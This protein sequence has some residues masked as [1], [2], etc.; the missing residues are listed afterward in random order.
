M[1]PVVRQLSPFA[2]NDAARTGKLRA[3]KFRAALLYLLCASL[4]PP[5]RAIVLN[6]RDYTPLAGWAAANQFREVGDGSR[7]RFTLTN[8]AAQRLVFAK[9]SVTAEINSVKVALS[10][11]VAQDKAGVFFIAQ[12]D[13]TKTV[14]PLIFAPPVPAKKITT[15]C[16]DPGHGGKDPGKQVGGHD[17][18]TY[19]LLLA[20]ELR[21]QLVQAG[22]KVVLTRSQ[23][24]FLTLSERA[25]VA[26]RSRADLLVCLH[27]NATE[28]AK[29]EV[30]GL[31]TYC[32][33]PVGASSTDAEGRGAG[34]SACVANRVEAR[35]LLL[36]YQVHR[37]LI[38]N[39][40]ATDRSVRRARFQVLCEATMPAVY[41]E[42]GYMTNPVEAKKIYDAGYRKQMAAA[43]VRG[44]LSYQQTTAPPPPPKPKKP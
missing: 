26:N 25:A 19:A 33:T 4:V 21:R 22:F 32:I 23:D 12:F 6:G 42:G 30:A 37:A 34:H 13:L 17:E 35:S 7:E 41:V 40:A 36:A 2:L 11:P 18:K 10:F 31:Q 39:L 43:I 1:H 15:I 24:K 3:V 38:K 9:N 44:I 29:N 16:L 14:Q 27:F 8:R 28:V 20:E 5:A